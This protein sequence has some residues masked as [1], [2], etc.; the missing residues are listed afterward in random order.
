MPVST[1]TAK[2]PVQCCCGRK[3]ELQK[4]RNTNG[5]TSF[6]LIHC[7]IPAFPA[8]L[9]RQRVN[10][11]AQLRFPAIQVWRPVSVVALA[12]TCCPPCQQ[13][14]ITPAVVKE[15]QAPLFKYP[16]R[17]TGQGNVLSVGAQH[18]VTSWK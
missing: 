2:V 9:M 17:Y 12:L 5:R 18:W 13:P 3:D 14:L 16:A 15:T 10:P 8:S 7:G 4:A 6:W 1:S 11:A